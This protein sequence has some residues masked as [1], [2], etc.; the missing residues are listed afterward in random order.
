MSAVS[1]KRAPRAPAQD[2]DNEEEDPLD[3]VSRDFA[4]ALAQIADSTKCQDVIVYD[5]APLISW[6]SYMVV[7]NVLS[8]PQLLAV[9]SRVE[10]AA[11][12]EWGREKKNVP[13]SSPWEV[14]KR[15]G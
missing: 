6:T 12:E 10:K 2:D 11:V 5:V 13:G 8:K 15:S 7:C 4:V 9:M 14:R 3:V 1:G